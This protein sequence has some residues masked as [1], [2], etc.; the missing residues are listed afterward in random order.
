MNEREIKL[1]IMDKAGI[2]AQIL[3]KGKD[4]ELRKD[5]NSVKILSIDKKIV[6]R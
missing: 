5:E 6:S 4:V 2:M 3:A 1:S